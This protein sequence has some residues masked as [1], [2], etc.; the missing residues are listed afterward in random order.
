MWEQI[1]ECLLFELWFLEIPVFSAGD[2]GPESSTGIW[3]HIS[4]VLYRRHKKKGGRKGRRVCE[5]VCVQ[6][7]VWTGGERN[8]EKRGRDRDGGKE[9]SHSL[10]LVLNFRKYECGWRWKGLNLKCLSPLLFLCLSFLAACCPPGTG[11]FQHTGVHYVIHS[12][13]P[14]PALRV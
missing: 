4:W 9:Q 13:S 6:K 3:M 14:H 2:W 7:S 12:K 5:R 10:H 1:A 11:Q 8:R